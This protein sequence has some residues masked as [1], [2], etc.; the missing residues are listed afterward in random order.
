MEV[1]FFID[2]MLRDQPPSS[3]IMHSSYALKI[4]QLNSNRYLQVCQFLCH[5]GYAHSNL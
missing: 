1:N 4:C 5:H 2:L 3:D